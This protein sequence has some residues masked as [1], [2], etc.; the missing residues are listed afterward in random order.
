MTELELYK[1]INDNDI[2]YHWHEDD[3]ILFVNFYLL[4]DF[5]KLLGYNMLDEEGII[6]HLKESYIAIW[7]FSICEHFDIVL[8]NIFKKE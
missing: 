2:E 3:V 5:T 7:M 6:C 4:N 8:G 1:F